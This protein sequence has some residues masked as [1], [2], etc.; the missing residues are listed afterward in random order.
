MSK[1]LKVV[2]VVASIGAAIVTAGASLGISAALLSGI[3]VAASIGAT[4]LA[5]KPKAPQ[6]SPESFERLR[7]SIDPRTPR[8][9]WIGN[10]AGAT[11]IRDEEFTDSQAYFHRFIVVASHKVQSIDEIWFDDKIAWSAVGGVQGEFVGYLTVAT[12]TEGSAANAINISARMG[13]TRRYTGLAYVHLRYKLTGNSKKT[14]S[15]FAQSITTR[16]TIRGKGVAL[17]DPRMDST[18]AGG[19]GSQRADDQTTWVWDNDACRNPA[20]ALL[21]YLLGYDI[22]GKLAVGKGIPPNRIDLESFAIA[23]NL[24]DE[25]VTKEGGG[26]EPRYRVDGV[27][28]E[29]DGPTTVMDMLKA[30]MNADLDDVDGK[31]RLTIFHDDLATPVAD[32]TENDVLGGFEWNPS[33]DLDNSFNIVRGVFTDPSNTSLYQAIDY[34]QLETDSP[35]GID[36]IET[37]NLPMVQSASQAQRLAQLRLQRQLF[38]GTFSAEFQATAWKVQKNSI[39]RLT[40]APRGFVN[41]LFRVADMEIRQD[42]VVPLVLREEDLAIYGPPTLA[43]PIDPIASTPYDPALNPIIQSFQTAAKTVVTRSIAYPVSSDDDSVDIVA[44]DGVL[45]DGQSVSFPIGSVTG[46]TSGEVYAVIYSL[47]S[48]TYSA[49]LSP[50][51]AALGN[52]TNVFLGWSTTSTGGVYPTPTTPPGGWGGGGGTWEAP[53]NA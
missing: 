5:P 3:G 12:R 52:D 4:L 42:G 24:C 35:D 16:I 37:F 31:L 44:F 45:N 27:W 18:V 17:Y 49:V 50:A 30:S 21:F 9:T 20:L 40:F 53:P 11:D 22:N 47:T 34:P 48:G 28:S 13:S 7:A 2:A 41:K 6:N 26:T 51:T 19:S 32:F 36:R 46:L 43:H 1:V 38:G 14:D 23:A 25:L 39:I 29:G 33:A 8:K 10:T 15:P